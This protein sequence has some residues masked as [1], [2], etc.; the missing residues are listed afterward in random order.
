MRFACT[1]HHRGDWNKITVGFQKLIQFKKPFRGQLNERV[2]WKDEVALWLD[3]L[4]DIFFA[5]S[6]LMDNFSCHAS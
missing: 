3:E 1:S 4:A 5:N 6:T 2:R